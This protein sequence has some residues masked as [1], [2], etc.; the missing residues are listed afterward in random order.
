[1][2]LRTGEVDRGREVSIIN[3][4]NLLNP[5]STK[6]RR[7]ARQGQKIRLVLLGQALASAL[8][9]VF[10]VSLATARKRPR[11]VKFVLS[12]L[13][14]A[15]THIHARK[16]PDG[17]FM[18]EATKTPRDS[19][20]MLHCRRGRAAYYCGTTPLSIQ[21]DWKKKAEFAN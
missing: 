13:L 1:M 5:T 3:W 20:R 6:L 8:F 9:F 11:E 2:Q 15:H 14:M 12:D 7:T 19:P 17:C 4:E 16:R 10:V 18:E 21:T